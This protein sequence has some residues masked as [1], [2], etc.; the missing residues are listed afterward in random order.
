MLF[1]KKNKSKGT[2][3]S[4]MKKRASKRID[5]F[6]LWMKRFGIGIAAV[7]LTLWVGAW[8]WL[9]GSIQSAAEYGFDKTIEITADAGFRVQNILVEGR[10]NTDSDVLMGI[11]NIQK[12]DPLL[13]FNPNEAQELIE[14]IAWVEKVRVERRFPDTIF[15]ELI[16]RV[17][18][19]L[20]QKD[21]RLFLI[22]QKGA[23]ITDFGLNRFQDLLLVSG[24][25][26]P[27]NAHPLIQNIKAEEILM[28]HIEAASYIS[29]RRWNLKTSSGISIKLP[30]EDIGFALRR[31]AL[32]QEEQDIFNKKLQHID[33]RDHDRIIVQVVPGEVQEYSINQ[34]KAGFKAGSNI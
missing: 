5:F 17:P 29:N 23:V 27:E 8:F 1:R 24:A 25:G 15:I 2:R 21:K 31:L 28:P 16:E 7:V 13:S 11:V 19:A 26:A 10:V 32:L 14:R 18:L 3:R 20:F 30:A 33:L 6:M 34:F 22:D 12:D 4:T 9:S